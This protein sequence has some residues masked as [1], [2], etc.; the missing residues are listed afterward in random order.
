MNHGDRDAGSFIGYAGSFSVPVG[1]FVL[2]F[3]LFQLILFCS[4]SSDNINQSIFT[5]NS[6]CLCHFQ[7]KQIFFEQ[8]RPKCR[9]RIPLQPSG[10][11]IS[12]W[13]WNR[14]FVQHYAFPDS[15]DIF[16]CFVRQKRDCSIAV[17]PP[18]HCIIQLIH[19]QKV[20]TKEQGF[21]LQIYIVIRLL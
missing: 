15:S 14:D 13:F 4:T 2:I 17:H 1:I 7:I 8:P 20:V 18:P 12:D 10:F 19:I 6:K 16:R 11:L 9:T 3:K 5:R 21:Q